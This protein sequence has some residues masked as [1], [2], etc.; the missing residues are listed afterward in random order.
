MGDSTNFVL[1]LAG[2]LLQKGEHLLKMGLHPS[3]VIDGYISAGKK[4]AEIMNSLAVESVADFASAAELKKVVKGVVASKQY[5]YEDMISDLVV[6]AALEIMP[7]NPA[8]FN[9][10]S[11]RVVKILGGSLQDTSVIKGMVFGREPEGAIH[12]ATNAK[13]A[14]FTCGLDVQ[15]TETKGTVLIH[16]AAEMLNF[17]SG[18]EKQ[19][20]QIIKSISE[21]GV[22]VV[23]SGSGVGEMALH[24]LNRYGIMVVKVFGSR[25]CSANLIFAVSVE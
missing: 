22:K 9:V 11:V 3:E 12:K 1:V 25:R 17:S 21:T 6:K 10:D 18:E 5:G 4:A 2:E 16:N 8:A 20:E 14:I 23:V 7:K 15:T 13:I 19:L 24:Y